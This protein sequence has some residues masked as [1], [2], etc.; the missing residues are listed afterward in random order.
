MMR[1]TDIV[2]GELL[3]RARLYG[4]RDQ[5]AYDTLSLAV[6]KISLVRAALQGGVLFNTD[7]IR[8]GGAIMLDRSYEN[9][10]G[11]IRPLE[12]QVP[13]EDYRVFI[14]HVGSTLKYRQPAA[15][16][17]E[18]LHRHEEYTPIQLLERAGKPMIHQHIEAYAHFV[19]EAWGYFVSM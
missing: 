9:I 3:E 19:D 7:T 13:G 8:V 12:P 17:T 18:G 6:G 2:G 11:V 14:Y 1:T 10:P 5:W 4:E 16:E 15:D